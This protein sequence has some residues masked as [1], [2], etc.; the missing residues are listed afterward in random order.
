[1]H[2]VALQGEPDYIHYSR[3]HDADYIAHAQAVKK[4]LALA[5]RSDSA[6]A[7]Q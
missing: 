2:I 3:E 5:V 4:G 6:V 1:M 7:Q